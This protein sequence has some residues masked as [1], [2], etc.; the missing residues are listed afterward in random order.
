MLQVL[1]LLG[2]TL[3]LIV[4]ALLTLYWRRHGMDGIL[5]TL[6]V[7][8]LAVGWRIAAVLPSY[9]L[10]SL[11][12][13]R[14]RNPQPLMSSLR[15]LAGEID[16]RAF[17]LTIAEPFHQLMMPTEPLGPRE[18]T[19]ILLVHGYVSNR[20]MMWKLRKRLAAA[21][22]GP[23]YTVNLHPLFGSIDEMVPVLAARIDAICRETGATVIHVVAHSMGGLV[24][25]AYLVAHAHVPRVSRLVTIGSPH[26]GTQMAAF[27]LGRCVQE[28]RPGSARLA[29]LVAAEAALPKLPT[30]SVYTLNDDLVYPAESSRLD[31]AENLPLAGTGHVSM[32]SS[33]PATQRIIAELRKPLS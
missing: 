20:G 24:T 23:V 4:Y 33:K 12:R 7:L 32:L 3:E 2:L 27:G 1:L 15:A 9:L 26:Q 16:A 22:L 11:F 6:F 8:M 14:A 21:A 19:P 10:S 30:L 18:G 29:A 25:R 17:T 31:W 13:L 5:I 28:M